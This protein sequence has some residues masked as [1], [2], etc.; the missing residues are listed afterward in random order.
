MRLRTL[1][2]VLLFSIVV[3]ACKRS[4][5]TILPPLTPVPSLDPTPASL[6]TAEPSLTPTL[7]PTPIPST[8]IEAGDQA[9]FDGGWEEALQE[10]QTAYEGSDDPHF[11]AAA[12]LGIG[13]SYLML[14][15]YYEAINKLNEIIRVYPESPQLAEAYYFM[16]QAHHAQEQPGEA[17]QAYSNYLTNRPG[18]IDAYISD[19]RGDEL[20]AAGDYSGAAS[21]YQTALESPE[22]LDETTL[23]MKIAR[24]YTLSKDYLT[25]LAIYDD[26]YNLTTHENTRALIDLRK[27]QIYTELGQNDQA[28]A[29]YQD[30]VAKF[31]TAPDT[32]FA[33]VALVEAGVTVD[34]LQRGII[35]YFAGQYGVA[36]S[37]FDRYLQNNPA[38]P[39]SAH[40]YY[41]LSLS[42][43]G[44][45][46]QALE[47]WDVVITE[48]PD[49]SYWD[50]AWEQ[51]AYTQ[52]YYLGQYP[53]AIQTFLNF[54]D[55]APGHPRAAE[56]L[57]DAALVSERAGQLNQAIE[58]W[59]RQVNTYPDYEQT[60]RALFLIGITEYRL[61][62]FLAASTTFQ[63]FLAVAVTLEEKAS[64]YFWIGKSQQSLEDIEAAHD[65]WYTAASIDPTGYYSERARD[66]LHDRSPFT[67]PQAYDIGFDQQTERAKADEW[68]RETFNL[69]EDTDLGILGLFVDQP[70]LQRGTELWK[71]GLYDEARA[72][73]E[74]LRQSFQSDPVQSYRLADY[75]V[76][77]G[78]YRPA[79]VAARQVLDLASMDDASSL[80]APAYF[81]HLRFGPYYSDLIIPL[82][83]DYGFHPLFLL[84][85]VRQESLFE[86]FVRSSADARGLMQI[87]PATGEDIA[88]NLG[89]PPDYTSEDLLRP[90]VNLTFGIDYLNTQRDS[91]DGDLFASLAAYNGG[92]GNAQEWNQLAKGDPDLF[93]EIIRFP[94]TRNYIRR[95]Y[96]VFTI[97]RMIYD[98][99]P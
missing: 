53:E 68:M 64:A 48:Y 11:K 65:S 26:Q 41:A 62:D 45:W 13:R 88:Q 63:R 97:Y 1:L 98:R 83:Q 22:T 23:R 35:D 4:A 76:Q 56:F 18:M 82:A 16:G 81:N 70:G 9:L 43:L 92:P 96:E 55:T 46:Q 7:A 59:E 51:K 19:L 44:E 95:V 93:L 77:I 33:L 30:A 25:A 20:F 24:S 17:A 47:H 84:S 2:E 10:Y 85:L 66:I 72:E 71:L 74:L 15:N 36:L 69:P 89:W 58:A 32:Y 49:H 37:A 54:A 52:W 29:A 42:A 80:G 57:F 78:A 28:I 31:P 34:E 75:L 38:D 67:P 8:R 5:P 50:D 21:S 14:R 27:G 3:I 73:F 99:T 94:E 40:H 61:G 91:F 87:I 86:S 6:T 79:I 90:L 39:G 60:P 12:L